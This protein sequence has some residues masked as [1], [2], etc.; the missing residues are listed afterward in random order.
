MLDIWISVGS[1]EGASKF[2]LRDISVI[3]PVVIHYVVLGL[4]L[5][6]SSCR[7]AVRIALSSQYYITY[8]SLVLNLSSNPEVSH[9]N[10]GSP[11]VT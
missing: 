6:C 1:W 2:I 5:F 10:Q 7:F 11:G 8:V 4:I 9:V 3:Y